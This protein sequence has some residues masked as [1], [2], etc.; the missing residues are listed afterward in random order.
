MKALRALRAL[1]PLKMISRN[2][3]MKLIVTSLLSS[4][5]SMTNVTIV[6][7]LFLLIFAI[8]GVDTFSGT[9]GSCTLTDP[10]ELKTLNILSKADCEKYG[11]EWYTPP[12]TFD[13]TLIGFRTLFE[14]MSTEGWIDVMN[15]GIDGV[16]KKGD[17]YMQP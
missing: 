14:M 3:G 4:L 17:M 8:M 13:N 1:R 15:N 11:Y 6:C 5:P 12:E 16:S 10:D 2:P 7:T 9:F